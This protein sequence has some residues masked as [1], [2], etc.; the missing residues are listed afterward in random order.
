MSAVP[1][2][3]VLL[4]NMLVGMAPGRALS[5]KEL[6]DF[7]P[8]AA[9]ARLM[10]RGHFTDSTFCEGDPLEVW[11]AQRLGWQPTPHSHE[12]EH[13]RPWNDAISGYVPWAMVNSTAP[14]NT[15]WWVSPVHIEVGRDGVRLVPP[16]ELALTET[17]ARA[18]WDL[19]Q[20]L[21]QAQG[22]QA[23]TQWGVPLSMGQLMQAPTPLNAKIHSPW[24]SGRRKLTD[25]LPNGPDLQEWRRLWMGLQMELHGHPVNEARNARGLP[26]VNAF[27]WWGGGEPWVSEVPKLALTVRDVFA[28]GHGQSVTPASQHRCA[29][30]LAPWLAGSETGLAQPLAWHVLEGLKPAAW[31]QQVPGFQSF[32]ADVLAGLQLMA[33]AHELVLLGQGCWRAARSG[34]GLRWKFWKNTPSPEQICETVEGLLDEADLAAA[35]QAAQAQQNSASAQW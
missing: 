27:W 28:S 19:A 21:L 2:I 17:E 4:P 10:A 13:E 25:Q 31:F 16:D 35:W 24:A 8:P 7:A 18:L 20:P 29:L 26:E 22:W 34:A 5:D 11:M 14:A 1:P 6:T 32:D 30:W 3:A 23:Q 12:D 15:R 33:V 9:C